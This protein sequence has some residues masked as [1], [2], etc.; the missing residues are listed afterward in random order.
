[1]AGVVLLPELTRRRLAASIC[2]QIS[3]AKRPYNCLRTFRHAKVVAASDAELC[4]CAK[5]DATVTASVMGT[6]EG[7]PDGGECWALPERWVPLLN[8]LFHVDGHPNVQQ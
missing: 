6:L 1:M 8:A 7:L 5:A 4:S 3:S 2:L